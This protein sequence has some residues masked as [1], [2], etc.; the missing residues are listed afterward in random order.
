MQEADRFVAA[1]QIEQG[2]QAFAARACQFGI[3]L[4]D[5]GCVLAGDFQEVGMGLEAGDTETGRAGLAGAE[6]LAFTT[7]LQILFRDQ[8]AVL[9]VAQDGKPG[10]AIFAERPL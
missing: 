9:A 8:E 3:A 7:Q 10:A 1:V 6:Q 2:A 5:I 4:D